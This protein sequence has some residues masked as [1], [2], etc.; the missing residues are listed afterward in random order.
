MGEASIFQCFWM[1]DIK[2]F[3][4]IMQPEFFRA[5]MKVVYFRPRNVCIFVE[6]VEG[7]GWDGSPFVVRS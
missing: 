4:G 7:F 6:P 2:N 3:Q 1:F 5:P